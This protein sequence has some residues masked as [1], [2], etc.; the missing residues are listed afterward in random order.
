HAV[1]NAVALA[2]VKG[3]ALEPCGRVAAGHLGADRL[4]GQAAL[5]REQ[6]LQAA[7]HQLELAL[8]R[9]LALELVQPATQA[10]VLALDAD[11]AHVRAPDVGDPPAGE[12]RRALHRRHDL[13]ERASERVDAA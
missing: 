8:L 6:A 11:E 10:A 13:E 7:V 5:Q 1:L 9:R 2:L 4:R 3:E 12:R